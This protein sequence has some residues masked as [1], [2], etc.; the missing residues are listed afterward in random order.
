[1]REVDSLASD[2]IEVGGLRVWIAVEA[3]VQPRLIVREGKKN[4]W[5]SARRVVL[6]RTLGEGE[7]TKQGRANRRFD[8][9][10]E[11]H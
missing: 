4:V 8:E 9:L 3:C 10:S 5:A 6:C 11:Q 1:M 7:A 2:S